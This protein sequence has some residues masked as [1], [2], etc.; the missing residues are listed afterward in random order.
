ML[1]II[2]S[3][4]AAVTAQD[5]C[6]SYALNNA[7][8]LKTRNPGLAGTGCLLRRPFTAD[9]LY[10]AVLSDIGDSYADSVF[11]WPWWKFWKS[12]KLHDF[13]ARSDGKNR[14]LCAYNNQRNT[15]FHFIKSNHSDWTHWTYK[16]LSS[17][18]TVRHK[19]IENPSEL[20]DLFEKMEL[21]F[22][23]ALKV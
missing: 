10:R 16:T 17:C 14:F 4:V 21:M 12:D 18:Q 19:T 2:L 15:D 22:C 7:G 3:L 8:S 23:I 1:W 5:N 9:T 6:Y 13:F 11:E 20:R